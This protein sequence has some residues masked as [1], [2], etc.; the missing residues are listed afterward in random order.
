MKRTFLFLAACALLLTVGC[1]KDPSN[2]N[3]TNDGTYAYVL[4]EGAIPTLQQ[5]TMC[6]PMC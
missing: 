6:A 4:N 2:N 3:S 1:E 5:A